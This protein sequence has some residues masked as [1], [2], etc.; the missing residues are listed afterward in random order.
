MQVLFMRDAP[1]AGQGVDP[2]SASRYLE[3][4]HSLSSVL[5]ESGSDETLLPKFLEAACQ[6]LNYEVAAL[7]GVDPISNSLRCLEFWKTSGAHLGDFECLSREIRF[8]PDVGL[9]GRVWVAGAAACVT[10]VTEDPNFPR[11]SAARLIG[12]RGGLAL[13]I[14]VLGEVVGVVEF[15][16]SR[17]EMPD[18]QLVKALGAAFA[19][20]GHLLKQYQATEISRAGDESVRTRNDL[21][22][23]VSHEV[24][25]SLNV[26]ILHALLQ[27]RPVKG[28]PAVPVE[29]A[30][31]S[32]L[33]AARSAQSLLGDIE[34]VLR[35]DDPVTPLRQ[36]SCAAAELIRESTE[37]FALVAAR[38][39]RSSAGDFATT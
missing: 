22:H 33:A 37:A 9:P 11:A 1:E 39:V 3:M 16:S 35:F 23:I 18:S 20:I 7:W 4:H 14:R 26:I 38:E 21:L 13:P 10:D 24:R 19:Q 36:R 34:E 8:L 32:I 15:F 30:M 25:N 31:E 5:A 17:S 6:A 28:P 12:L 2:A 27:N 29:K